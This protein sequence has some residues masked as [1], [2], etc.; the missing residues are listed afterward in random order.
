MA[1]NQFVFTGN[2][3]GDPE[4]KTYDN[5]NGTVAIVVDLNVAQNLSD[6][7][8]PKWWQVRFRGVMSSNPQN[9]SLPERVM[10]Q[11]KKGDQ[12]VIIGRM[13]DYVRQ[14]DSQT[15]LYIEANNFQRFDRIKR[16]M[17]EEGPP[18]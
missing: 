10:D 3:G 5:E 6:P 17:A 2:A 15:V 11:V 14:K 1:I 8:N 13:A 16:E 7:K 18:V 12:V 9:K 4:M